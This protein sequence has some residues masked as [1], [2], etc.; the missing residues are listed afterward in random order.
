LRANAELFYGTR[1]TNIFGETIDS[2]NSSRGGG[3]VD[4]AWSFNKS[5]FVNVQARAGAITR[6]RADNVIADF[7]LG[8]F[9]QLSGLRTNQLSGNYVGFAPGLSYQPIATLPH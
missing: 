4:A 3:V 8:G 1:S 9:L 5:T 6:A 2:E 7:N